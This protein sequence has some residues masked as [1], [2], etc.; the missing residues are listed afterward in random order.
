[1]T[2]YSFIAA[3]C[4]PLLWS[5]PNILCRISVRGASILLHASNVFT[6]QEVVNQPWSEIMDCHPSEGNPFPQHLKTVECWVPKCN[7]CIRLHFN[8]SSLSEQLCGGVLPIVMRPPHTITD[9]PPYWSLFA[10]LE[11]WSHFPDFLWIWILESFWRPNMD[12]SVKR[13]LSHCSSLQ[14]TCWQLHFSHPL[15]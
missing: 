5:V 3:S 4:E 13:I 1:M 9:A 15:L 7:L 8:L 14:L 10:V 11:G 12:S 6:F 2:T